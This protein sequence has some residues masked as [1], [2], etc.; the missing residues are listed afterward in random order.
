MELTAGTRGKRIYV[1]AHLLL[2]SCSTANQASS[3]LFPPVHRTFSEYATTQWPLCCYSTASCAAAY[4]VFLV[5][6]SFVMYPF[7]R[8]AE[9]P[10]CSAR[11]S[12]FNFLGVGLGFVTSAQ[13]TFAWILLSQIV[14]AIVTV[15]TRPSPR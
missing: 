11:G 7:L 9:P 15:R 1:Y 4:D 13:P 12:V 5:A 3:C 14:L 10:R 8:A 6:V 2:C